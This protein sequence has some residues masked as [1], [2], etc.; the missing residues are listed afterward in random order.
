MTKGLIDPVETCQRAI[1]AGLLV[2]AGMCE[3]PGPAILCPKCG[4]AA[5]MNGP[6]FAVRL[7]SE[8]GL[9]RI[10]SP[11]P[12]PSSKLLLRKKR[13]GGNKKWIVTRKTRPDLYQ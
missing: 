2:P 11:P 12:A 5:M 6:L 8:V 13:N 3:H 9:Q 1:Q 10:K 4:P 7:P